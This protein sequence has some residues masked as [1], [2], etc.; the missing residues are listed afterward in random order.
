MPV[1]RT[2]HPPPACKAESLRWLGLEG[3]HGDG[4]ELHAGARARQHGIRNGGEVEGARAGRVREPRAYPRGSAGSS[5]GG[6]TP[7][8][9]PV[10]ADSPFPET[11]RIGN[12]S[13]AAPA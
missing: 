7:R 11:K 9:D 8:P 13:V 2:P 3:P 6:L 1:P 12:G 4:T 10:E 5:A